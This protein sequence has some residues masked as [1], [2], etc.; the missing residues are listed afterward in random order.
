MQAGVSRGQRFYFQKIMVFLPIQ[1][2]FMS[3]NT[4]LVKNEDHKVKT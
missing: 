4:I 1:S 3:K 2:A